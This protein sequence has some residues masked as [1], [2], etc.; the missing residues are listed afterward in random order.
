M[1]WLV[2]D[3]GYRKPTGLMGMGTM[4]TDQG[5]DDLTHGKPVPA[6]AGLASMLNGGES[7]L[8]SIM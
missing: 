2:I 5:L 8:L 7:R 4:G 1:A 6:S 3:T